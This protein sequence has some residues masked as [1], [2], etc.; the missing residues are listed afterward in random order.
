MN[1]LE[2]TL[3]QLEKSNPGLAKRL[4]DSKRLQEQRAYPERYETL[5]VI[6]EE[7]CI[8]KQ[9]DGS[10]LIWIK[11]HQE[12][13]EFMKECPCKAVKL[14]EKKLMGARSAGRV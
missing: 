10:G 9:C 3:K 5:T 11:D 13:R 7:N 1:S 14:L 12:N 2:D 6:S 4:K 8:Y